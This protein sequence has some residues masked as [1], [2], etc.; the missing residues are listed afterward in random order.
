MWKSWDVLEGGGG[1][2]L[3]PLQ[4]SI[5]YNS[6]DMYEKDE[7][8][9]SRGDRRVW[10]TGR[11]VEVR[12]QT[13]MSS[14]WD[15]RCREGSEVLRLILGRACCSSSIEDKIWSH[16]NINKDVQPE[17]RHGKHVPGPYFVPLSA[18]QVVLRT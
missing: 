5:C 4:F 14:A 2:E 7:G 16:K 8:G 1:G 18:W 3:G 15:A 6:L 10:K 9:R 11:R 17:N 12:V 13:S